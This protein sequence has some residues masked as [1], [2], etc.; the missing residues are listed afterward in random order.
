[1]TLGRVLLD[2]PLP[3]GIL[4]EAER[5]VLVLAGEVEQDLGGAFG[6]DAVIAAAR[7]LD[8]GLLHGEALERIEH[9]HEDGPER[10]VGE[11]RALTEAG[12]EQLV[13]GQPGARGD[14]EHLAHVAYEEALL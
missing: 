9:A 14:E 13:E 5:V 12:D 11:R 7:E 10:R 6:V 4:D 8:D 1:M 2:P 3:L